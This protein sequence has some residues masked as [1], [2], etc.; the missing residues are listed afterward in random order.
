MKSIE[1]DLIV[2]LTND[3]NFDI[4]VE[5]PCKLNLVNEK[6][7]KDISKYKIV[8]EKGSFTLIII[9]IT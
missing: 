7:N 3:K 9:E 8:V 5:L 1:T 2:K 6:E 4:E